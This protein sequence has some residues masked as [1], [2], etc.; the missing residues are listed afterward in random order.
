VLGLER[1]GWRRGTPLDGGVQCWLA[2]PVGDGRNAVIGLEPGIAAG[3]PNIL[4]PQKIHEV[5]IVSGPVQD[6]YY[7]QDGRPFSELD[8]ATISEILRDVHS[9]TS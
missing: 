2:R 5:R 9:L 4:G 7:Q 6:Y 3:D 1:R 8:P